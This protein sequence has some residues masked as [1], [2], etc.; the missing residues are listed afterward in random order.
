LSLINSFIFIFFL[1]IC[2]SI[3]FLFIYNKSFRLLNKNLYT[4]YY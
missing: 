3:Y 4:R 1:P 2:F